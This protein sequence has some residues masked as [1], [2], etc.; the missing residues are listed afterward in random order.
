MI[1]G[2]HWSAATKSERIEAGSGLSVFRLGMSPRVFFQRA[3]A[4]HQSGNCHK[5][6]GRLRWVGGNENGFGVALGGD[7]A[8][9]APL[10]SLDLPVEKISPRRLIRE[11]RQVAVQSREKAQSAVRLS[12]GTARCRARGV[13]DDVVVESRRL[14]LEPSSLF[15]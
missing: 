5:E 13:A 3:S 15:R 12:W 9:I 6:V 7:E 4:R 2:Q 14:L 11:C 1:A 8:G 10:P